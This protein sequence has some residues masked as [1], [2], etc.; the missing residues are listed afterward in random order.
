MPDP[1]TD[2]LDP[3]RHRISYLKNPVDIGN[4]MLLVSG[5]VKPRLSARFNDEKE[6]LL[7]HTG[8][9]VSIVDTAFARKVGRYI[10][11]KYG[12]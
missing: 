10:G 2:D 9:E 12:H 4:I 3:R 11:L 5:S 8:A 1:S 6:I 7:L